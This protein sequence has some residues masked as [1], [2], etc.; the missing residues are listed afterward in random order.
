MLSVPVPDFDAAS[1]VSDTL[2]QHTVTEFFADLVITFRAEG[3]P[4][5]SVIV[6]VQQDPKDGKR[7]SWPVY[8]ATVR[9]RE[10]CPAALLVVCPSRTVAAWAAQP[11][12]CGPG[13]GVTPLAVAPDMVPPITDP[14]RAARTPELAVLSAL[15]HA[16][17]PGREQIF[18]AMLKGI[19]TLEPEQAALYFDYLMQKLSAAARQELEA[20]V[21]TKPY[22]YKSDFA[23]RME[24]RGEA[25]GLLMVLEVRGVEVTDA[26]R[27]R[28]TGCTDP[29]Q[30][31]RW[32]RRA[33]TVT[34]VEEVFAEDS[35]A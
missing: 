11:I 35:P 30:L 17:D 13:W 25:R 8:L 32:M 14:A 26:A 34:S 19:D 9:K 6:E 24:A 23:R 21:L 2:T 31:D 10:R 15:G 27:Q 5:M 33:L 12:D 20:L 28:I 1:T 22:E 3:R 4:V 16:D 7:W 29:E 18:H